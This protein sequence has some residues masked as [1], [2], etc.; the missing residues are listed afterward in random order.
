MYKFLS[1]KLNSRLSRQNPKTTP[2]Q[3]KIAKMSKN[4]SQ[5]SARKV[6]LKS[7]RSFPGGQPSLRL[8][9]GQVENIPWTFFEGQGHCP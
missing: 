2:T 7:S 6:T 8:R 3:P 5:K 9:Q 1:E 4:V